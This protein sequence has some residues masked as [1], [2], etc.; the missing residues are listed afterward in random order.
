M[1]ERA[2]GEENQHSGGLTI[3]GF[4]NKDYGLALVLVSVCPGPGSD[5]ILGLSSVSLS[6]LVL[7]LGPARTLIQSCTLPSSGSVL[8]QV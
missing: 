7:S 1:F 3:R 6:G 8:A 5:F 2:A 4:L